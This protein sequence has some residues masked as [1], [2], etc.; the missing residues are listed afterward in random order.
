MEFDSEKNLEIE[1]VDVGA[2][3]VPKI[4]Q[5]NQVR[6]TVCAAAREKNNA[7]WNVDWTMDGHTAIVMRQKCMRQ[8]GELW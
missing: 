1:Y 2:T 4:N 5:W 3:A 8:T 6:C 7:R